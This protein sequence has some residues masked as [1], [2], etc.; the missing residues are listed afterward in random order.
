MLYAQYHLC[1]YLRHQAL[2][3]LPAVKIPGNTNLLG[4]RGYKNKLS[5]PAGVRLGIHLILLSFQ[6]LL[7]TNTS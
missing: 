6:A 4:L 1:K 5:G 3:G 7:Y 2:H